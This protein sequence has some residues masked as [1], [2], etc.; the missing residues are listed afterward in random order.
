MHGSLITNSVSDDS[1]PDFR[2]QCISIKQVALTPR[3]SQSVAYNFFFFFGG[4]GGR[5][6]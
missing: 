1:V 2:V 4:G 5:G 3:M 6:Y